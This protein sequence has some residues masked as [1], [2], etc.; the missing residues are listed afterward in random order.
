MDLY[1]K[2]KK[3]KLIDYKAPFPIFFLISISKLTNFCEFFC[4]ELQ[5]ALVQYSNLKIFSL[6]EK[7]AEPTHT[8][9][10]EGRAHWTLAMFDQKNT[11]EKSNLDVFEYLVWTAWDM[12]LHCEVGQTRPPDTGYLIK[13]KMITWAVPSGPVLM[14][15]SW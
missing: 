10:F 5:I 4:N 12:S 11:L 14:L 13:I 1:T 3:W 2:D 8:Q 6:Q 9:A 15:Y 7:K